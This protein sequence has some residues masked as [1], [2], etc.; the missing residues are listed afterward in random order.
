MSLNK[1]NID[2][3]W[4]TITPKLY[5]YLIHILHDRNLAEDILQTTWLKAIQALPH[6]KDR[7]GASFSSWLFSIARNECKQHWRKAGREI[8]FDPEIHDK[9]EVDSKQED[10]IFIDQIMTRFSE[11][12]R[13]LIRLYYIADLSLNDIAKLL[14]INPITVRVRMHR[15]LALVKSIFKNQQL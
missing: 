5:G 7:T 1:D 9:E 2:V 11:S 8:S 12:D 3:L 13:E 6:F 15:A 10:K 14:K 4:D